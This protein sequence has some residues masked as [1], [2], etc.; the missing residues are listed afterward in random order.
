MKRFIL[1]SLT[2]LFFTSPPCI[3]AQ[4]NISVW[5]K[6]ISEKENQLKVIDSSLAEIRQDVQKMKADKE[7]L[8][9]RKKEI[10]REILE[11]KA[12]IYDYEAAEPVWAEGF[13]E[14]MLEEGKKPAECKRLALMYARRDAMEKGGKMIIESLTKMER[15]E[16]I[17]ENE[18]GTH[19]EYME[20]FRNIIES[21]SKVQVIDQDTSDDYGKI[22]LVKEDGA[23]KYIVKVRLKVKSIDNYN[24]YRIQLNNLKK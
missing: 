4:D 8:Y 9:K 17:T 20:R 13:G 12:R 24:P 10:E 19:S 21:K 22:M 16:T 11:L 7:D 23:K 1:F 3:I 15:V 18:T 2:F 5:L 6:T 14:A